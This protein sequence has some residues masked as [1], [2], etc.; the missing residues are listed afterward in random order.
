MSQFIVQSGSKQYIVEPKQ[1]LQV[2]RINN[3]EIGDEVELPVV[4]S[5][6]KAVKSIKAKVINQNKGKKI[7][8]VKYKAK[9]NYH[10]VAG[11]R[12]YLT[13]LEIQ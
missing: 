12:P 3:V 8:I 1:Y 10:K 13:T 6:G 4:F 11:F 5:F 2:D 7:R 9:S